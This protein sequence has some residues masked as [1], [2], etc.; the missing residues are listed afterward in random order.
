ML[1]SRSRRAWSAARRC[2][3]LGFEGKWA[4]HPSQIDLANEVSPLPPARELDMLLTTGER[5][6]AAL[7]AMALSDLGVPARGD[8]DECVGLLDPG[9]HD[10]AGAMVLEAA[11]DEVDAVGE[12][13]RGQRVAG[14]ARAVAALEAERT[15]RAA[16]DQ[17]AALRQA[18]G[19][20]AAGHGAWVRLDRVCLDRVGRA[21]AAPLGGSV[22]TWDSAI[23]SSVARVSSDAAAV[24]RNT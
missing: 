5:Q 2:A 9:G 11:A 12:Q 6:S 23:A 3:A 7:L 1:G 13:G 8:G 20:M 16:V 21:A 14:E 22:P 24:F 18:E 10:P 19:V 17:A 4:I 15:R